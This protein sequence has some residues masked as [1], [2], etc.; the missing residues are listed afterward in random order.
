M[1]KRHN[2]YRKMSGSNDHGGSSSS[3]AAAGSSWTQ[4]GNEG[5]ATAGCGTGRESNF[6][7]LAARQ[8]EELTHDLLLD[9]AQMPALTHI[10]ASVRPGNVRADHGLT[11]RFTGTPSRP[12]SI[13]FVWPQYLDI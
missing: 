12:D 7:R 1:G 8:D 13:G 10:R 4:A 2:N 6:D 5:T 11:I 3:S 9:G